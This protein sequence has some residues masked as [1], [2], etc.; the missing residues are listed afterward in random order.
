MFTFYFGLI[1]G[2]VVFMKYVLIELLKYKNRW[3]VKLFYRL[4]GNLSFM[5]IG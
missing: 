5:V 3:F 4:G 1:M 2:L